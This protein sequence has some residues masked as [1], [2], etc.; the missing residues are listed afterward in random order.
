VYLPRLEDQRKFVSLQVSSLC[1]LT[2]VRLDAYEAANPNSS[3]NNIVNFAHCCV[4]LRLLV[5]SCLSTTDTPYSL[6]YSLLRIRLLD[7][8]GLLSSGLESTLAIHVNYGSV[9]AFKTRAPARQ[10]HLYHGCQV[11]HPPSAGDTSATINGP[12][13]PLPH[14]LLP[15]LCSMASGLEKYDFHEHPLPQTD[16]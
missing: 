14:I 4:F 8:S 11:A 10:S 7:A 13:Q 16:G 9:E 3:N 12:R 1:S 5:Q 15:S 2:Q 6:P